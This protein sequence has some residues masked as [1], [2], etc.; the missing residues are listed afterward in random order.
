MAKKLFSWTNKRYDQ[1]YWGR[2][3]RNWNRWKGSQWK[4]NRPDK[5]RT[6][7]EMI[8]EEEE[9]EQEELGIREQTAEDKDNM[10]NIVDPYYKL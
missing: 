6:T 2:L 1:E 8:E 7:L 4:K 9:I 10:D 3:E 5:R